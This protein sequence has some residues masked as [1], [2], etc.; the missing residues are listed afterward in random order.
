[1]TDVTFIAVDHGND[2]WRL[3]R[4]SV[5][6]TQLANEHGSD[7]LLRPLT[8]D[9]LGSEGSRHTQFHGGAR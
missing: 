1:M 5:Q 2:L 9:E 8:P 6:P 7:Q 3:P 4:N